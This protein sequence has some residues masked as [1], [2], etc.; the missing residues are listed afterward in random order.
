LAVT[1]MRRKNKRLYLDI[2]ISVWK[3]MREEC[4]RR[5][6]IEGSYVSLS[7]LVIQVMN[8]VLGSKRPEA[9]AQRSR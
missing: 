3:M 1:S 7:R 4:N 9:Q 2:P 8:E 5:R 6:A